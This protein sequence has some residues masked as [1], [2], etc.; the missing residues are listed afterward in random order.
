M[1]KNEIPAL[2]PDLARKLTKY[3]WLISLIVF[4]VIASLRKLAIHTDVSFKWLA[5]FHSGINALTAFGILLALYFI[6][7][8]KIG[9]HRRWMTIN[10]ILSCVFLVSYIIY[11]ITTPD[12]IYCHQG[13]IRY[14]YFFILITHILLAA[15]VLPIILFTYLRAYTGQIALHKKMAQWSIW[16]WFYVAM[17]GPIVYLLLKDC[18]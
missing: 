11:H 18:M 17:T 6:K 10:M 5:A 9:L 7:Q 2:N 4:M 16:L 1:Y 14:L 8:G 13:S 3:I 15:V 12:T